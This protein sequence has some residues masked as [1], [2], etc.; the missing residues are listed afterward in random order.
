M[1]ALTRVRAL[2][3]ALAAVAACLTGCSAGPRATCGVVIDL[4]GFT[5][6]AEPAKTSKQLI[7]Q[8]LPK[9]LDECGWLA[10]AAITGNSEGSPCQEQSRPL[11]ANTGNSRV[12][13]E[14]RAQLVKKALDR[15]EA[16]RNCKLDPSKGTDVFGALRVLSDRMAAAPD[17]SAPRRI[18]IFSDLQ[19]NRPPLEE[20]A[21][22]LA[23]EQDRA[24]KVAEF[25]KG[26]FL[27]DLGPARLTV[28]GF[29]LLEEQDTRCVPPLKALW[30]EI[31]TAA[32][33]PDAEFL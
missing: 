27:P 13:D 28:Y 14:A 2:I 26:G 24:R 22:D 6:F 4:T 19:N 12:D 20:R 21:C 25:Q 8:E 3:V 10:Y 9:F 1:N 11:E 30:Q 31:F 5:A 17:R 7:D 33:V 32:G 23:D 18:V 29:N 16:L 15:A